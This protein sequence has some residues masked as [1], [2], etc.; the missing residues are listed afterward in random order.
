VLL[1]EAGLDAQGIEAQIR[2]RLSEQQRLR[3]AR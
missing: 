3:E 1:A 2:T